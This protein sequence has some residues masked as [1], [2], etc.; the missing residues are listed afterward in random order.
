[1]HSY[2]LTRLGQGP[3]E[4]LYI[5]ACEISFV[6]R[7]RHPVKSVIGVGCRIKQSHLQGRD[8]DSVILLEEVSKSANLVLKIP[9]FVN[10][11]QVEKH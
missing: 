7:L 6:V 4:G 5:W 8:Y 9:E 10:G 1:M 2:I 11:D 3:F